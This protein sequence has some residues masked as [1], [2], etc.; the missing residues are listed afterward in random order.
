MPFQQNAASHSSV[1]LKNCGKEPA[2]GFGPAVRR[3]AFG[4]RAG[5]WQIT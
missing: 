4:R 3:P 2:V 5:G 1:I